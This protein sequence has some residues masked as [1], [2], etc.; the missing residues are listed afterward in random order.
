MSRCEVHPD[1]RRARIPPPIRP[2][3]LPLI[4]ALLR[5]QARIP[6]KGVETLKVP[7]GPD[8][9]LHRP[10]E[11]EGPVPA[12]LWMHGGGYLF[13][14]AR[15]DDGWCAAVARLLGIAVAAVDYRLAP[16]HV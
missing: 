4:R 15:Q 14:H 10:R 3:T 5:I 6:S 11:V 13:G 2:I 7:A 12:L 9:R 8:V 16:E 1:L